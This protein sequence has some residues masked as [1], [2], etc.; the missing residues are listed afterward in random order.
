MNNRLKLA[1]C[2]AALPTPEPVDGARVADVARTHD[3]D[4]LGPPPA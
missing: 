1:I 3:I 4:I 2:T